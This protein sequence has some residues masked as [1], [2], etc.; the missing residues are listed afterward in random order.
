MVKATV[1]ITIERKLRERI[2]EELKKEGCLFS[3]RSRFIEY[4][5]MKLFYPSRRADI[6]VSKKEK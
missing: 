3:N 6:S 5:L 2:D 1:S 4:H